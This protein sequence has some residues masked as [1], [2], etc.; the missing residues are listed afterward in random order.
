M[1]SNEMTRDGRRLARLAQGIKWVYRLHRRGQLPDRP[2]PLGLGCT[3]YDSGGLLLS[4]PGSWW[5]SVQSHV[6]P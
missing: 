6:I 1:R 2:T 4:Q 5:L 3:E